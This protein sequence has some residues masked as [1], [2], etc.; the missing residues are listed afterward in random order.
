MKNQRQLKGEPLVNLTEGSRTTDKVAGFVGVSRNTLKKAEYIV[1]AAE[2]DLE[3][4][5]YMN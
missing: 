2:K 1:N 5:Q 4:Y 3:L